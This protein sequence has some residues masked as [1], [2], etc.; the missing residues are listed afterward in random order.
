MSFKV[1]NE[2][3][4]Q[5]TLEY[6]WAP[7]A[8]DNGIW[9]ESLEEAKELADGGDVY[10][11]TVYNGPISKLDE[12]D[13]ALTPS[14]V[15][16]FQDSSQHGIDSRESVREGLIELRN[17][18]LTIPRWDETLLLSHAIWWLA[19]HEQVPASVVSEDTMDSLVETGA[20]AISNTYIMLGGQECQAYARLALTAV[21][22]LAVAMWKRDLIGIQG[23]EKEPVPK[24]LLTPDP[25]LM[26]SPEGDTKGLQELRDDAAHYMGPGLDD[27]WEN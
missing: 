23:M 7:T 25:A 14:Y 21:L 8:G 11:R 6:S 10:V 16:E 22:P 24:E 17:A 26:A 18:M 15:I 5:V 2:P 9:T 27:M 13:S 12:E 4:G 20:A 1:E 19:D 3:R